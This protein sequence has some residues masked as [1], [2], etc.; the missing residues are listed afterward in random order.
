[1][2][3]KESS[4]ARHVV[5]IGLS[6]AVIL[7]VV[8]LMV[9]LYQTV[10]SG[11]ESSFLRDPQVIAVAIGLILSVLFVERWRSLEGKVDNLANDQRARLNDMERF[12][13][14]RTHEAIGET[15]DKAE[16]LSAKLAV[17]LDDHPWLEVVTE[18]DFIVETDSVRGILRTAYSL[19]REDK[20][21]HLYEYLEYCS[22]K[23]TLRGTADDFLEIAG[24]CE[25][26]LEDYA[27]GTEF[28]RRYLETS[29]GA[30]YILVPDLLMRLV[31][32]GQFPLA[33]KRSAELERILQR[34]RW[35]RRLPF[36][37][38]R[39]PI[40]ERYRWSAANALAVSHAAYGQ[41]RKREFFASEARASRYAELFPNEQ[42]LYA[43][44]MALHLGEFP[45]ALA[46]LDQVDL[47]D[48]S[49]VRRREIV[50]LYERLGA[51][52]RGLPHRRLIAGSRE[53]AHGDV[54]GLGVPGLGVPGNGFVG[55]EPVAAHR[56]AAAGSRGREP[57]MAVQAP[58]RA[59]PEPGPDRQ[60]GT[61]PAL[62]DH[63]TGTSPE[64]D[65]TGRTTDE[66]AR[67]PGVDGHG[68]SA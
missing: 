31:R 7:I 37:F 29:G 8:A 54:P 60:T 19:L 4:A 61:E 41:S 64:P 46:T 25:V 56:A 28:L 3:G 34:D 67:E 55:T 24:F 12:T 36:L 39:V 43:A 9:S 63:G 17:V 22:R 32:M 47:A 57:G 59:E 38:R 45:A 48:E 20:V 62:P 58:D 1:M 53:S 30:S 2:F 52:D 68:R 21:L 23:G 51:Y 35:W 50:F 11:G 33:A 40:S 16:K 65:G 26:W 10:T 14:E 6:V 18:R 49:L 44:E 27:L 5:T 13:N 15:V 66:P 42:R